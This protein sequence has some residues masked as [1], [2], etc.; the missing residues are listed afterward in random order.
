MTTAILI[1]AVSACIAALTA[2]RAR[3]GGRDGAIWFVVSLGW[4]IAT[5]TAAI[6]IGIPAFL[7]GLISGDV[8]DLG[9]LAYGAVAIV[10]ACLPLWVVSMTGGTVSASR[11]Q[12]PRYGRRAR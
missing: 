9:V 2:Q 4:A 3:A 11:E 8:N 7:I 5:G 1:L 12:R 6:V 10:L